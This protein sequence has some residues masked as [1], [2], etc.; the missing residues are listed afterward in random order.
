[1]SKILCLYY[2]RTGTTR[3][4]VKQLSEL[5]DMEIVRITDG[6]RR[7]GALGFWKS[8]FDAMKK[9]PERLCPFATNHYLDEYDHVI[10]A[11]PVWA[12]RCSSVAKAFL[13]K[14]GKQLPERV[15][16]VIT[17]SGDDSYEEVFRQMDQYIP[18]RH[19]RGLSLQPKEDDRHQKVYDF[20]RVILAIE[21]EHA[22]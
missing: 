21:E 13:I 19:C 5:I 2:S 20:A 3:E 12:G 7:K 17:H 11:T 18:V 10:L 14:H 9:T 4:V 6:K 15:S 1:M 8:G 16:F 22:R